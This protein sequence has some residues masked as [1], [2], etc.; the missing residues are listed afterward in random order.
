MG[1]FSLL[2]IWQGDVHVA[3]DVVLEEDKSLTTVLETGIRFLAPGDR[4]PNLGEHNLLRNAW[5]YS[6]L[7]LPARSFLDGRCRSTF[8]RAVFEP[9]RATPSSQAGLS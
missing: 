4:Q 3:E 8:G 5:P 1:L 7:A 6:G 9:Q 2:L